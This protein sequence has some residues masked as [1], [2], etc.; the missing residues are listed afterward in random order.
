MPS[1]YFTEDNRCI[2]HYFFCARFSGLSRIVCEEQKLSGVWVTNSPSNELQKEKVVPFQQVPSLRFRSP[3]R[4]ILIEIAKNC[5]KLK[6][7]TNALT[8]MPLSPRSTWAIAEEK[9][10]STL[11]SILKDLSSYRVQWKYC[12]SST[13]D[14]WRQLP[15]T[16]KLMTKMETNNFRTFI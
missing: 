5:H 16:D 2:I 15:V 10:L 9:T 3:A 12:D 11:L 8:P 6:S 13:F 7:V 1:K 14:C 4:I